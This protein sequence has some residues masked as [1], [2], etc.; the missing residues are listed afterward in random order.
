M[1]V[2]PYFG[3]GCNEQGFDYGADRGYQREGIFRYRKKRE[4]DPVPDK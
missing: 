4:G 2:L 3:G 1:M